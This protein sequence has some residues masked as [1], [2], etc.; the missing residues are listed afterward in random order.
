MRG[1]TGKFAGATGD[2]TNVGEADLVSGQ[3]VLRYSGKVCF[4]QAD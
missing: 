4:A 3:I 1:G 2:L